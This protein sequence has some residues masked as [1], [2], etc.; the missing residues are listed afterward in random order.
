[1]GARRAR[2]GRS[3]A[4]TRRSRVLRLEAGWRRQAL[5]AQL[6][7]MDPRRHTDQAAAPAAAAGRR[8]RALSGCRRHSARDRLS[9]A[10]QVPARAASSS[11]CSR[12]P[13]SAR[14]RERPF[15]RSA[16]PAVLAAPLER[17]RPAWPGAPQSRTEGRAS[18]I[19]PG[20]ARA[21]AAAW[22]R[23]CGLRRRA[24]RGQ[25]VDARAALPQGARARSVRGAAA[26]AAVAESEARS[27]CCMAKWS[28][29]SS[30][31]AST[32]AG[33]SPLPR[34][35]AIRGPAARIRRRRRDR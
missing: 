23:C 33:R 17:G 22:P 18:R 15:A 5:H 16:R 34:R 26:E 11:D 24:A 28:A 14:A 32:R 13:G 10:V 12:R 31:Q 8:H 6:T 4:A 21:R 3:R 27:F 7:I 30:R 1:M 19:R 35:A 20:G 2:C 25:G 29:S 9:E